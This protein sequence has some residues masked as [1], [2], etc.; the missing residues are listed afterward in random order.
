MYPEILTNECWLKVDKASSES[1]GIEALKA[2]RIE[3]TKAKTC[4]N[5]TINGK[6]NIIK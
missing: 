5:S 1:E 3:T 4:S 2:E 6:S